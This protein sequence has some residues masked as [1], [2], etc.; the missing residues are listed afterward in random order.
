MASISDYIFQGE[1][2][3]GGMGC[4][5]D[6]RE[7]VTGK[8]VAIKMLRAESLDADILDLFNSEVAALRRMHSDLVVNMVG[9]QFSDNNN[10]LY[11]PMEF[12]EGETLSQHIGR[13]GPMS[14]REALQ[15]MLSILEGIAYIHSVG[16]IHRD[17][18]PS[19]IMLRPDG[20]P[21]I[22][23]F[24]IVRDA[25]SRRHENLVVGTDGYM[26]PEQENGLSLDRR[27]DI[28]AA[29]CLLRYML[30]GSHTPT[31][32]P[33]SRPVLNILERATNP[34]MLLRY[35]TADDMEH[36]IERLTDGPGTQHRRKRR[37]AVSVGRSEGDIIM[38]NG[39]VSA[40]H[41]TI[42][43]SPQ[44]D[45]TLLIDIRDHSTNGTFVN[46]QL[47]KHDSFSFIFNGDTTRLPEVWLY[48]SSNRLPW[49]YVLRIM[50]QQGPLPSPVA[51]GATP[52]PAD[53]F[54]V[55]GYLPQPDESQLDPIMAVL[56]FALPP[57][58]LVLGIQR[59]ES[60]RQ[61][62]LLLVFSIIGS[63]VYLIILL[64]FIINR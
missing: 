22:I 3:R 5:F 64:I 27:A 4:V 53:T 47:I 12:V 25:R 50:A 6:A 40:R 45:G 58:G 56:A 52:Q 60:P 41:L 30:T 35:A 36:D 34:N 23:D 13:T 9:E 11:I 57:V 38:G 51:G 39:Y 8:R 37:F 29:G 32:I 16:V 24:G 18:K 20:K 33:A 44:N 59:K 19:N 48:D 2:G 63:L 14:E 55:G 46:G 43:C 15:L 21:C 62:H 54:G 31:Q 61:S 1:V 7:V 49:D 26:S 17:L 42:E 28:Y 10:N